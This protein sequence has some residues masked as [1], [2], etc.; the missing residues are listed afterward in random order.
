MKYAPLLLAILTWPAM[1]LIAA[2]HNWP[3]F[4]G[5]DS[6][7]VADESNLSQKWSETENVA[8]K[9]PIAGG[10]WSSPIV[11]NGRVFLTGVVNKGDTETVKRGLYFGG[12][13]PE[14]P[15]TE[16]E[17]HVYCLDLE[18]GSIVWQKVAHTGIPATPRH[19]K[20]S[21]ASETP[22][23]DGERLYAYFGN[24]G[25][26][27]YDLE[28]ELLWTHT[29]PK[30]ATRH[31]W[32]SAASPVV[33]AGRVYVVND[34]DDESFLEALDA[35]TGETIWRT[36]RDEKSNWATP[37]IWENELRTEI[38]TPGTGAVRSYDLDG[39]QLWELGGMS[40][41]TIP[42]PFSG[43]GLLYVTSGYVNDKKKPLFAIR[44]GASGDISLG[45]D[46][47]AG[48]FIAWCQ[49]EAGPYNPSPIL[50]GDYVYVLLDRGFLTCYDAKTG[51]QVYD[52]QRLEGG[53]AF[54]ASPWAADGKIFCLN[55]F[56]ATF[57]IQ[58]GAEFKLLDTNELDEE[59]LYM[60]TPALAGDR[61]LIRSETHLYSIAGG[62]S[63]AV[64]GGR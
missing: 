61:L 3:Q 47:T 48:E 7:G 51:E 49:K 20:N 36:Q 8:W 35:R 39:R 52:K 21:F 63:G 60:A 64:S 41:I 9:M 43:H 5:A 30:V 11:W 62:E 10:G 1:T 6:R 12:N 23:T 56:G 55:E 54:T 42:M 40:S 27:C 17:W 4:R 53:R 45:D 19:L 37:Y 50:Y 22:V 58:A 18:S 44:P 29:W 33:H 57:V 26:Y 46:E 59:P 14:P 2:E 15:E 25:L 34:N 16:H 24:V 32:G 13:R 31:A 28:G 38:I